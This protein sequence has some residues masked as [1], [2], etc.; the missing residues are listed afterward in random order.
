MRNPLIIVFVA[1]ALAACDR[2]PAP[3]AT[4]P[5]AATP[6]PPSTVASPS[7]VTPP[8]VGPRPAEGAISYMG[9]GPAHW[10]ASEEEVRQSWGR[11]MD[12]TPN[13]PNGCY[14]LFP[15]PRADSGYR[16]GFMLEAGKLSRID[17][18]VSD[19]V[20][21]GGGR[22]GMDE[23]ALRALYPAMTK[24]PHKYTKGALNLRAMDPKGG[25]G[26]LVFETDEAGKAVAWRVGVP[27]QVDYVEG[28]G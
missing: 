4:T 24:E 10:G 1:C 8:A 25:T 26:V 16:F 28:C 12:G 3:D 15:L 18:R 11:D 23:A 21:P 13:E 9:F 2:S 6:T 19:I 7:T 27:P 14:Y 17:V 20:A 5:E 22:V